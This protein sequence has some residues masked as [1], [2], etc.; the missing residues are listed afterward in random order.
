[1]RSRQEEE[2]KG[3]GMSEGKSECMMIEIRTEK[4][5]EEYERSGRDYFLSFPLQS[6]YTFIPS[7][8][9]FISILLSDL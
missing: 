4:Q 9:L 2:N 5:G 8:L 6:C 7:L 3:E 1:M